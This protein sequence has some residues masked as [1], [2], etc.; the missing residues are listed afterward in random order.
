MNTLQ[1]LWR[2]PI[3]LTVP[4]FAI[5]LAVFGIPMIG[6]FLTTLNAPDFSIGNYQAFF[7]QRANV[8]VLLQTIEISVVA[9]A[10]C[11][12]IGYP[13]A[14]LIVAAPK[15]IRIALI[16]LVI[17]PYLTSGLARTYAWILIL[18]G[19]GLI[20][21]L[22]VYLGLISNPLSL[23]YNRSAVYIGM[24]HI[25]LPMM[26]IPLVSVMQGI[27]KSL[28]AAARSM[29]AAPFTAFWRV[30]F[31]LSLP[32]V[33]SGSLLVFIVCLGFYITPASLGG[34]R[35]AMLS[36]FIASQV[37][38]SFD[39]SY[40]ATAA[41]MLLAIAALVLSMVGFDF[42]GERGRRSPVAVLGIV[43]RV[44]SKIFAPY[45]A[46]RWIAQLYKAG[47]HSPWTKIAGAGFM[48]VV[49][50]YLLFPEL[51]VIVMSFSG[52]PY[53]EFPPSELSLRWYRSF[54][55]AQ[56][57]TRAVW[58]SIQIGLP[59][60]VLST[61]I[62][63][64]AAY[65]LAR[66]LPGL[67][68]LLT[69]IMLTPITFPVVVVGVAIYF[70]L[71]NFGLVGT[72][73]GVVLAHTVGSLAFVVVIVSATLANF[74][75]RLEQAAKS[76]RAGPLQTFF[77]VTLPLVRPG[78]IA[79]AVFAFIHSFDEIVIT[80]FVG[81]FAIETLPIKMWENM[82]N[83]IDPT[84]AAAG[85]LLTLLPVVWLVVLYVAWWRLRLRGQPDRSLPNT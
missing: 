19:H 72:K 31:P 13:M 78:I 12:L 83:T 7:A 35:D 79:G 73:P 61:I 63:T 81:G 14:Y 53:L 84:I 80:S 48:V 21:N 17:V 30:F 47:G 54:F 11:L 29:G 51:V 22:L 1:K 59:V 32:G 16:V 75:W 34:L 6:L 10:I 55:T 64:L 33:R 8:V 3:G 52:K 27:D 45:R 82:N 68:G 39:L 69:M 38:N 36:S 85:S 23:I 60:T 57:W 26:I 28:M 15:R 50:F 56:S 65:G 70:G 71:V 43:A 66:T 41:F 4:A 25:M 24:V 2:T 18:G 67:R 5:L 76:M 62:G 74:D 9:T 77:R 46:Q 20:N 40:I 42:S 44:L 49:L 58:T 37:R